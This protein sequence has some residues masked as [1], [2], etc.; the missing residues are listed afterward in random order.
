MQTQHLNLIGNMGNERVE[1][2]YL[3]FVTSYI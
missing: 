1:I 3:E 2:Y